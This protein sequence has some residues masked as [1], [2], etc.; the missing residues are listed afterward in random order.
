MK[1]KVLLF[2]LIIFVL[3][4]SLGYS[5][6][7]KLT[8]WKW[9]TDPAVDPVLQQLVEEWN[10]LHPD[11]TIELLILPE[12][13]EAE[14]ILKIEQ[15]TE[16]GQGPDIIVGNDVIAPVLAYDGFLE[17]VPEEVLKEVKSALL[18]S[19][20][21][22]LYFMGP[23]GIKRPYVAA[24]QIFGHFVLFVND[25]HLAGIGYPEN[26]CPEDWNELVEA[27]SKLT[28]RDPS[29]GELKR[30][31]MYV[32]V[33]GHI[34]GVTDKFDTW[35]RSAGGRFLWCENGEWKTDINSEPGKRALNLYLDL[36]YKHKVYEVGFPGDTI[37]GFVNG[38]VSM[39]YRK[40]FH[41]AVVTKEK[42]DLKFHV[43]PIP[44]YNGTKS[45][46]STAGYN[47]FSVNSKSSDEAKKWAWEFI[48]WYNKPEQIMRI[49]NEV[50]NWLP[51]KSVAENPPF[52]GNPL[53]EAAA[54]VPRVEPR[55]VHPKM[56]II[57]NIA[58]KYIQLA[59][60]KDMSPIDAL[61]AAADEILEIANEIPCKG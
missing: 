12:L 37:P 57:Y 20:D 48:K 5:T 59:L 6:P 3:I 47:T 34:G 46:V 42:P 28:I 60:L 32:R 24:F 1:E 7:V 17:P 43:C 44:G 61:N 19:Y 23:D 8:M 15:A 41:I 38:L 55:A 11:A 10:K 29:T 27:A 26:W 51:Y 52:K 53:W 4:F 56:G 40:T 13:S 21:G 35:L 58:G 50:N 45:S 39:N 16:A 14:F 33:T 22:L 30:A 49:G 36:L 54:K 2:S 18:P 25:E 9:G 31:G